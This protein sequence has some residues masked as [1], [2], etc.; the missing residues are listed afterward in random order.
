MLQ[1][2]VLRVARPTDRLNEVVEFYTQ[3]LGLEVL[4]KFQDH[5]GFDGVRLGF[6][7]ASYHLEFISHQGHCVGKAP[8]EDNLL[9]FYLPNHAEWRN[10]IAR[11]ENA[12]Y[13]TVPAYNPYWDKNGLTF[14]DPDDYRVVLQNDTWNL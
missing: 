9:V 3:G 2:K 6:P 4:Y 12:G 13:Q 10:A 8:T 11:M 14:A 1:A 5:E 7:D